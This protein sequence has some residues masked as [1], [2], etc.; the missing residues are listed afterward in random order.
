MANSGFCKTNALKK[1]LK[2][3]WEKLKKVRFFKKKKQIQ[4]IN[5]L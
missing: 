2:V 3:R 1:A 4:V 5:V